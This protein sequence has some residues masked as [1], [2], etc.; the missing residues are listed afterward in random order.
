MEGQME[1]LSNEQAVARMCERAAVRG[2][3]QYL[4]AHHLKADSAAL[5]ACIMSWIKA[6]LPEAVNDA[7]DAFKIPGMEKIAEATFAATM[8]QAGIEAAKEAGFPA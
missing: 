3:Q 8:V 1:F 6:K 5:S 4:A 2:A 7:M